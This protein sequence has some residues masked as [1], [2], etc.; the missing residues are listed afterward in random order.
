MEITKE[1]V[2]KIVEN[3]SFLTGDL[4]SIVFRGVILSHTG[5]VSQ[6]WSAND[7]ITL[8]TC[9]GLTLYYGIAS[10]DIA[11]CEFDIN[12]YA[13]EAIKRKADEFKQKIIDEVIYEEDN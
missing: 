8:R 4:G 13:I 11:S 2:D 1:L 5:S 10:Q 9:D 3:G 7:M 12:K 6:L